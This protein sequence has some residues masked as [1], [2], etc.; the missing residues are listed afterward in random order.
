MEGGA[1]FDIDQG[2]GVHGKQRSA[3][4]QG[5]DQEGGDGAKDTKFQ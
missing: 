5:Q 2:V 4:A 3:R 1:H